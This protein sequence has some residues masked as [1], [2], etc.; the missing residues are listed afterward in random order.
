ML[1]IRR[2]RQLKIDPTK[3]LSVIHQH[4]NGSNDPPVDNLPAFDPSVQFDELYDAE[5]P[6]W[7]IG[8]PSVSLLSLCFCFCFNI[9]N[10]EDKAEPA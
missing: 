9:D 3:N 6:N 4:R 7:P 10:V 5:D 1:R 2:K 8:T